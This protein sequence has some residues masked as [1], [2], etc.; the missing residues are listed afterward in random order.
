MKLLLKDKNQVYGL[1]SST[2]SVKIV[3]EKYKKNQC[4]K[5]C[6]H[7]TE[8]NQLMEVKFNVIFFLDAI[9]HIIPSALN[10]I[11]ANMFNLL[12]SGGY[13]I[14]TTVNNENLTLS[15]VACPECGCVFHRMQHLSSWN[16]ESIKTFFEQAGFKTVCSEGV[17]FE[18]KTFIT[19]IKN[20]LR[21]ILRIKLKKDKLVYIGVKP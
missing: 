4:F 3:N 2:E 14:V 11:V 16:P 17:Y 9:E 13:V 12:D 1:D 7:S 21:K 6:V 18:R 10:D 20:I 5:K 8:V 19:R 15:K